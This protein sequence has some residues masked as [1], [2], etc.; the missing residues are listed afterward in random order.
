MI[1]EKLQPHYQEKLATHRIET[2]DELN[3]LRSRLEASMSIN[4]VTNKDRR[5]Q[6][7]SEHDGTQRNDK[8][9]YAQH[10]E[11]TRK[12]NKYNKN[13]DKQDNQGDK[14]HNPKYDESKGNIRC[15]KC[16]KEGHFAL[17]CKSR[18]KEQ[19]NTVQETVC[20]SEKEAEKTAISPIMTVG[21][22]GYNKC[23]LG[24]GR[25]TTLIQKVR[26]ND[27]EVNAAID[28]GAHVS[29]LSVLCQL[30]LNVSAYTG[31]PN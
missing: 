12:F 10:R 28:T 14:S 2:L 11:T 16:H 26:I 24:V 27:L 4:N 21:N 13:G 17:Q 5:S 20:E 7:N 18:S 6:K 8:R 19:V 23:L 15:F 3:D 9:K 22:A 1:C 25:G 29:V 30:L 31:A